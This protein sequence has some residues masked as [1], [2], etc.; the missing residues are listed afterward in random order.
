ML[1]DSLDANIII[2]GIVGSPSC[3]RE[4][5]WKFL[6]TA[7][8]THRVFDLAVS[9]VVYVLDTFYEQTRREIAEN[10]TLFFEQLE[11]YLD[12][13]HTITK[14]ILPFWV[15]HPSLSFND[16]CLG[17]YAEFENVEPI[18]TLDKKLASQHPSAK[19]LI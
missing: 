17:F 2:H 13:N 5:I 14:M 8:T 18:I 3:Q 4:K 16:C 10:L 19:L 6:S 15:E 1:S 11:E 9:E 7:G 12:Y